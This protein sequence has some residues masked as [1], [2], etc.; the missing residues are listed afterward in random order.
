[1]R[2]Y[3]IAILC[4][5]ILLFLPVSVFAG[6]GEIDRMLSEKFPGL[7]QI[8]AEQLIE[9]GEITRFFYED[10]P[11]ALFPHLS[12]TLDERLLEE[13]SR[14]SLT[15]GVES[16]YLLPVPGLSVPAEASADNEQMLA[17]YNT[18]RSISSLK[19]IE[20]YSASRKRMR[21][22]FK[23]AYVI[24]GPDTGDPLPDPLEDTIP[25]ENSIYIFQQDLTFG[26]N[27]SQ[28]VYRYS[29][30]DISLSLTNLS[31]MRY[32]LLPFVREQKM[33]THLLILPAENWIFFYGFIGVETISFLGIEK[34]KSD[35]FYNRLKA[36]YTWFSENLSL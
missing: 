31:V 21:T 13:I 9:Q 17:I 6:D 14:L 11:P 12:G 20:Y 5:I 22:L 29:G 30:R 36:L 33:Q 4:I 3:R 15:I 25:E 10:T 8:E 28:A 32:A 18:L 27:V 34:K 24:A 23:D 16:I 26:K 1:M 2:N 19:G 35:S 7:R